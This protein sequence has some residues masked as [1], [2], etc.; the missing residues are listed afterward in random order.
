MHLASGV[1][2]GF[3]RN[4]II[5]SWAQG[6]ERSRLCPIAGNWNRSDEAVAR[7]NHVVDHTRARMLR[8]IAGRSQIQC[9]DEIIKHGFKV[10]IR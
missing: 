5:I 3:A 6:E 1:R 4:S 2:A 8:V 10:R 7:Q 9:G